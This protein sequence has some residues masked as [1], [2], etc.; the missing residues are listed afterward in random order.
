MSKADYV[1]YSGFGKREYFLTGQTL[2]IK[3]EVPQKGDFEASFNL[4]DTSPEFDRL[5]IRADL[6]VVYFLVV[7]VIGFGAYLMETKVLNLDKFDV[8]PILTI[9]FTCLWIMFMVVN[10]LQKHKIARF[11]NHSGTVLF[12]I[13]S[14]I[15]KVDTY[16][17]FVA[18]TIDVIK[19]TQQATN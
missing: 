2:T 15:T 11:K 19:D 18:K 9:L 6:P 13:I 12:D 5:N 17:E 8:L 16:D 14:S 3:G 7:G 1:S 10:A 4:K